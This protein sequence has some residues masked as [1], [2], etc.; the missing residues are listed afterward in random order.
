MGYHDISTWAMD[1]KDHKHP[2]MNQPG[3]HVSCSMSLELFQ[4]IPSHFT[5]SGTSFSRTCFE[6][7]LAAID[8]ATTFVGS[9]KACLFGFAFDV[10]FSRWK[11]EK[12][13]P[14]GNWMVNISTRFLVGKLNANHFKWLKTHLFSDF[15][16]WRWS[17]FDIMKRWLDHHCIVKKSK[18]KS[19][20]Q[21]GGT[22]TL[23]RQTL[24][25]QNLGGREVFFFKFN[26][27][28]AKQSK[29]V[30]W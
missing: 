19:S 28:S 15:L 12:S 1:K 6:A 3:F 10:F 13:E 2:V 26:V 18:Q 23:A 14:S 11:C 4:P 5:I 30:C 9:G 20:W 7:T 27:I 25:N 29:K 21:C 17:I 16:R 8:S 22:S 24:Y